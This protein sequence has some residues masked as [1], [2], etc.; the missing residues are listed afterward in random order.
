VYHG[1]AICTRHRR[2]C[3]HAGGCAW[4]GWGLEELGEEVGEAKCDDGAVE[5]DA[6]AREAPVALLVDQVE[7]HR[8]HVHPHKPKDCP[9]EPADPPTPPQRARG[10]S[11]AWM[12][13]AR[14]AGRPTRTGSTPPPRCT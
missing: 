1:G 5:D 12:F 7:A 9:S 14:T 6:G 8:Q 3:W 2:R 4:R 13:R 11:G 10:G